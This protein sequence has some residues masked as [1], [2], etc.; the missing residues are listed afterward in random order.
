MRCNS[1]W[2]SESEGYA[3]PRWSVAED[4]STWASFLIL[5]TESAEGYDAEDGLGDEKAER[6]LRL[7]VTIIVATVTVAMDLL[8]MIWVVPWADERFH[9]PFMSVGYIIAFF[10]VLCNLVVLLSLLAYMF[11][12]DSYPSDRWI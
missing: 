10:A 7:R 9:N 6:G 4:S 1:S 3:C 5:L 2:T 12:Q 11:H 8:V